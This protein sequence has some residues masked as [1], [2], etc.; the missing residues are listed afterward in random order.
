[1]YDF[2]EESPIGGQSMLIMAHVLAFPLESSF[3]RRDA[4]MQE[5]AERKRELL[6]MLSAEVNRLVCAEHVSEG[7][8][9]CRIKRAKAIIAGHEGACGNLR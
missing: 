7:Q 6:E 3:N 5:E 2:H 1:M 4:R 8:K 9:W